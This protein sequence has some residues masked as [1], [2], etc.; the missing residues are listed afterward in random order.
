MRLPDRLAYMLF[1][2]GTGHRDNQLLELGRPFLW[3]IPVAAVLGLFSA[4]LEGLGLAGWGYHAK[5]EYIEVDSIVP[6]L[7][8]TARML[9]K[10]GEQ[11]DAGKLP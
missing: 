7:Y 9:M 10:L 3:A 1:P 6:R 11:A 8:L 2:V 5:N 4:V